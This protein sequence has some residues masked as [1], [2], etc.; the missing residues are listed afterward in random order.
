[1][2]RL[3][4]NKT[5]ITPQPVPFRSMLTNPARVTALCTKA[6]KLIMLV[7][8]RTPVIQ[9]LVH[10]VRSSK[11]SQDAVLMITHSA[12]VVRRQDV[13]AILR[14]IHLLTAQTVLT[15]ASILVITPVIRTARQLTPILLTRQ[16]VLTVSQTAVVTSLVITTNLVV[17]QVALIRQ[18]L[19]PVVL[20]QSLTAAAALAEDVNPVV[21][22]IVMKPDV[23]AGLIP[24]PMVAAVPEHVARL[25][26]PAVEAQADAHILMKY[27]MPVITEKIYTS[28][29]PVLIRKHAHQNAICMIMYLN[30]MVMAG[31]LML[32]VS[33]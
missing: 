14:Q 4:A 9:T 2:L 18:V 12:P 31:S 26:H 5:D 27:G 33:I 21:L 6:V 19:V 15:D 30:V 22:L 8:V 32:D 17:R 10:P 25:V 13:R 11:K 23:L 28:A 16:D 3:G 1:M 29:P 20:T 24:V 7:L